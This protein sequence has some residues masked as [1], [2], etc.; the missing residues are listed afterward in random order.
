M[1]LSNSVYFIFLSFLQVTNINVYDDLGIAVMK[2]CYQ[3]VGEVY[4]GF[5]VGWSGVVFKEA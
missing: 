3:P 4:V 5:E 1:I 2:I